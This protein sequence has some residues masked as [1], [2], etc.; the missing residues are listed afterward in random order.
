[1]LVELLRPGGVELARR[2][3]AALAL[4][5]REDREAIVASIEQR[6][7]ELYPLGP[8]PQRTLDL[9]SPPVQ[10]R[11]YSEQ[12]VRTFEVR[13]EPAPKGGK[14]GKKRRADSRT[15]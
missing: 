9:V 12:V 5:P 14:A 4:A 7:S 11:G 8:A 1:M 13:P 6:M 15:A 3:L 2:W 10:R